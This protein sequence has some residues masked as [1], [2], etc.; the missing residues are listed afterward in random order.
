M[1][2]RPRGVGERTMSQLDLAR[3]QFAMTSIYH[4]LFVPVTIGLGFLTALLQTGWHRTGRPR[5]TAPDQVL[6]HRAGHQRRGRRGHR[7]GPGVPVRHGLVAVLPHGGRRLRRAAG[8]GGPGSVLPGVHIPR[9]VAVRLGQAA[10]A[11]APGDDLG[12]GLRRR[13]V[14]GVHHGRQLLDAAPGRLQDQH[15]HRPPAAERRLG[16]VHQPGLPARLRPR[17]A[18][19]PGHRSAGDAGRV[20]LAAAPGQRPRSLR[21]AGETLAGRPGARSCW[22]CWSAASWG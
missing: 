8:D 12:G 1:R 13:P 11:R 6:R 15:G 7:A 18:R 3:L 10:Q 14:R 2:E 20:G 9:F 4:F 5:T 19:L 21:P 22:R 17:P 16:A